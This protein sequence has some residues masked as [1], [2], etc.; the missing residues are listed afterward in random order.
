MTRQIQFTFTPTDPSGQTP[1]DYGLNEI[2]GTYRE[3]LT[4]L[5]RNPLVVSGTFHLAHATT[6]PFLNVNQ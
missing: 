6:V 1:T 2:G 5:H 4:G 3:T